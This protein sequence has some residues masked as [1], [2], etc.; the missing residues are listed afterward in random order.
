MMRYTQAE[1]MEIINLV[2]ASELSIRRT[3]QELDVPRSTFY[4]WYQRYQREGYEGLANQS[5]AALRFW[6]KIPQQVKDEV[7]ELALAEPEKSPREL[8]WQFTDEH[9][10]YISESSVYRILRQF[11][12]VTSPVYQMIPAK[13]KFERLTKR[14]NEMWQT[15]FTYFKVLGWGWYYLCTV[16]DDYSRYILAWRLAPTMAATDVQETLD[17]AFAE[18]NLTHIKVRHRPRLLSDN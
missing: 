16:L 15:D 10:Y 11:D 13:D 17:Q 9:E 2:E 18:T 1:K 14:V 5:H 8:A 12:L 3:L 6:N 4:R 7:V